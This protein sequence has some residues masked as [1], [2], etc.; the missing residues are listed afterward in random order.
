MPRPRRFALEP[1]PLR[2]SKSEEPLQDFGGRAVYCRRGYQRRIF[3]FATLD[4]MAAAPRY[5][6][7]YSRIINI[8]QERSRT[9]I[10]NKPCKVALGRILAGMMLAYFLPESISDMIKLQRMQSI[11]RSLDNISRSL[12]LYGFKLFGLALSSAACRAMK[13]TTTGL[14]VKPILRC[15]LFRSIDRHGCSCFVR[16]STSAS[17]SPLVIR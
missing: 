8:G 14:E 10:F 4:A 1:Y 6:L 11:A 15:R 13:P 2:F 7:R 5:E 9:E 3:A 17:R 16:D 12:A